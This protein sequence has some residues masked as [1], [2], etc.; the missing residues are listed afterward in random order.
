MGL[1]VPSP[2]KRWSTWREGK[3]RDPMRERWRRSA[4]NEHRGSRVGIGIGVLFATVA[5]ALAATA[6]GEDPVVDLHEALARGE[7]ALESV[8]GTGG[9]SGTVLQG[10]LVSGS[11]AY[12]A[13]DVRMA[14]PMYFRNRGSRQNMVATQLYGRD[15]SYVSDGERAFV[16]LGPGERL[17]IMFVAYCVDFEKDNPTSADVFSVTTI[18]SEIDRIVRRIAVYER[19]HPEADTTVAAQLAL[20][21][22][23]GHELKA[24]R[25]KFEF[26]A[27]DLA[28]MEV[29]LR[30]APGPGATPDS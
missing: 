21:V 6:Y 11:E 22:A 12:V 28:V 7:V 25:A 9:S 8:S 2:R 29:I 18:P 14:V 20:W 27:A 23:Q 30:A 13:I 10:R 4:G 5:V 19:A 24:I 17:P 16:R 26:A 3:R 1:G 15:G